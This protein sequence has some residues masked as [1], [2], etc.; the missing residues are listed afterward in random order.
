[1]HYSIKCSLQNTLKRNWNLPRVLKVLA[2]LSEQDLNL[3]K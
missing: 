1:V 3:H 2:Q